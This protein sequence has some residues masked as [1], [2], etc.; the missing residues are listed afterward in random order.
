META[1]ST[2][3]I[4]DLTAPEIHVL[5]HGPPGRFRDGYEAFEQAVLELV[6]HGWLSV[7][8]L[9]GILRS[10][11]DVRFIRGKRDD[12]PEDGPLFAAFRLFNEGFSKGWAPD[13]GLPVFVLW[14]ALDDRCGGSNSYVDMEVLPSLRA[15]GLYELSD[16]GIIGMLMRGGWRRTQDGDQLRGELQSLLSEAR[17]GFS[18]WVREEPVKALGF[19]ERSGAAMLLLPSLYDEVARLPGVHVGGTGSTP[20]GLGPEVFE[21]LSVVFGA[22]DG[23][24]RRH[25]DD[26]RGGTTGLGG[27]GG[28]GSGGGCGGDGGGAAGGH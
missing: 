7:R 28:I 3:T 20:G 14:Q 5:A 1:H 12:V 15:R 17:R 11:S 9:P 16:S 23:S 21:L 10:Q 27:F 22:L 19:L 13:D 24:G 4:K 18:S 8:E 2:T 25:S 26:W 6:G